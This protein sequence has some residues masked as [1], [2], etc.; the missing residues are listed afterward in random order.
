MYGTVFSVL[1][2]VKNLRSSEGGFS[3][4]ATDILFSSGLVS[5]MRASDLRKLDLASVDP[6]EAFEA[7]KESN[8]KDMKR[9]LVRNIEIDTENPDFE[10]LKK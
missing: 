9:K 8:N 2:L 1:Q 3:S 4:N 10:S 7:M 5:T 6:F